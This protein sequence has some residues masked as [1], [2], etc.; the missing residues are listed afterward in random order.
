M[1]NVRGHSRF[2]LCAWLLAACALSGTPSSDAGPG[3]RLDPMERNMLLAALDKVIQLRVD[4]SAAAVCIASK[5]SKLAAWRSA[6]AE[7]RRL[8][9]APVPVVPE[10]RCPPPYARMFVYVDSLGRSDAPER[11]PGYGDPYTLEVIEFTAFPDSASTTVR[12]LHGT[13]GQDYTCVVSSSPRRWTARCVS[14]RAWLSLFEITERRAITAWQPADRAA[15]NTR[16]TQ[17][18][19][20]Q[21]LPPQAQESSLDERRWKA[22]RRPCGRLSGLREPKNVS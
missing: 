19:A 6:A 5:E 16:F 10:E 20:A 8:L 12:V 1:A 13:G 21:R 22:L 2:V 15:P 7:F 14:W 18:V 11:P 4:S 17:R 3:P 9:T